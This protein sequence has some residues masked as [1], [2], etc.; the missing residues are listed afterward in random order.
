MRHTNANDVELETSL[1]QLAFDL[2]GDA[3]ETNMGVGIDS[4]RSHGF[5][6]VCELNKDGRVSLLGPIPKRS[7]DGDWRNEQS[8][9]CKGEEQ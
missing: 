3:I 6:L 9:E 1:Q 5:E 8:S 4:R 2:G 7:L